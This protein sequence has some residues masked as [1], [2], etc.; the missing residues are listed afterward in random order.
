LSGDGEGPASR[1]DAWRLERWTPAAE[2]GRG[3]VVRLAATGADVYTDLLA[4]SGDGRLAVLGSHKEPLVV[5]RAPGYEAQ[6]LAAGASMAAAVSADGLRIV[7][8]HQ[9]GSLRLW[10]AASGRLLATAGL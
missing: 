2:T 3:P 10:D 4:I 6:K 1:H 9:D 5:R 8:G 7:S